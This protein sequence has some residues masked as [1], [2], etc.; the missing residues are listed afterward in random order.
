MTNALTYV[1]KNGIPSEKAYPYTAKDGKCNKK[2]ETIYKI[3]GWASVPPNSG[4]Q[5]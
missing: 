5:L 1:Q 2:V 4:A 3:S